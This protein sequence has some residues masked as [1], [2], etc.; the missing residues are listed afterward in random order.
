MVMMTWRALH[1]PGRE[2]HMPRWQGRLTVGIL[3]Q[4]R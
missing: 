3:L 2:M 1:A 4:Q